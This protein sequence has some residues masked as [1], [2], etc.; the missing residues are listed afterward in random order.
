MSFQIYKAFV[1][2]AL[3]LF[4]YGCSTS[5][6]V[7]RVDSTK[8]ISKIY[9]QKNDKVS[10]EEFLPE[11]LNQLNE[12]GFAAE[13]YSGEAPEL[14][15][16]YLTYNANWMFDMDLNYF[17]ASLYEQGSQLGFSKLIGEVEYDAKMGDSNLNKFGHTA[18]KIRPLLQELFV[19]VK[20]SPIPKLPT[21]E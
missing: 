15:T 3:V 5:Q 9:V 12:L 7:V 16:Y 4:L 17:K 6:K 14:A 13:S 8:D 1:F 10:R 2:L 18:D 11:L 21:L 20:R 19:K